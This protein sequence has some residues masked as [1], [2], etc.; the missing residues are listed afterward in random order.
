[1]IDKM[2]VDADLCIKLGGSDKYRYL[3]DILPL[4]SNKIYMHTYAYSEVMLPSSAVKQLEF[5]YLQLMR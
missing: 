2:I 3:Y 4:I 1:M 5:R